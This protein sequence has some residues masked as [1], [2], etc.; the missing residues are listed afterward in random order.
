[1]LLIIF[2][3]ILASVKEQQSFSG[4]IFLFFFINIKTEFTGFTCKSIKLPHM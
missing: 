2:Q 3:S 4:L 1:M